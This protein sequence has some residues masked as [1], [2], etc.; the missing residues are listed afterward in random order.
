MAILA[1]NNAYLKIDN[2]VVNAYFKRVRIEPSAV[3]IDVTGGSGATDVQRV[4]GL[5]DTSITITL[6]YDTTSLQSYVQHIARG[7]VVEIEYGPESNVS[8]KPRHVQSFLIMSAAP[9]EQNVQKDEVVFEIQGS[10][11]AAASVD[12]FAGGV[13]S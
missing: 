13:Y 8:G 3:E 5:N 6:Q 9:S 1:D 7:Q 12:M 11:A 10:G 2:V 4:A